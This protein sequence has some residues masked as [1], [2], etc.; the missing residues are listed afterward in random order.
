MDKYYIWLVELK[1]LGPVNQRKLLKKFKNPE[2]IYNATEEELVN[3]KGIGEK[4]ANNI[5]ENKSLIKANKIIEEVKKNKIKILTIN[6]ELYDER[7]KEIDKMPI[8][9]Y[10]KGNIKKNDK[11]IGIVGSRRCTT[12]A[13]DITKNISKYLA[14]NDITIVS[15][16][17]KG[18]DSY[19]H[20]ACLNANGYTIA[21]LGSG[22]DIC[23]P[24]EHI[25][26]YRKIIGNGAV[27]SEYPP[28]TKAYPQNFA[29]RDFLISCFSD[30]LFVAQASKK[31]GSLITANY[32]MKLNKE[33]YALPN[34]IDIKESIG[35]NNLILKG[36][37]IL[38]NKNQLFKEENQENNNIVN[39]DKVKIKDEIKK[40]II[41]LIK[42][43][44]LTKNQLKV[45]FPKNDIN[46]KLFELE[47]NDEIK[48]V[49]RL[50]RII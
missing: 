2:S 22:V 16:M 12:Y 10:Y 38:L 24:K 17:A 50:Y 5:F 1:N 46:Q 44:K 13:K 27:I 14:I 4:R 8:V 45:K 35:T 30:K 39:D 48:V 42:K 41:D 11:R 9:L 34:K 3:I 19:A 29:K 21:I 37:T 36:A 26:L 6:D 20:S 31:S 49:S 15:G 7:L 33:V 18:I 40:Q 32:M 47:F 28:G 43:E 25:K 23:Y